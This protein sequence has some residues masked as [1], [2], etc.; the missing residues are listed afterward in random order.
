MGKKSIWLF[1]QFRA[2]HG[3]F[4]ARQSITVRAGEMMVYVCVIP[5]VCLFFS[6]R[7][8]CFEN[9][10]PD[11]SIDYII[12][13][14]FI[15]DNRSILRELV[16]ERTID[17]I[18]RKKIS[19]AFFRS[20]GFNQIFTASIKVFWFKNNFPLF[21]YQVWMRNIRIFFRFGGIERITTRAS[22]GDC[23]KELNIHF[24]NQLKYFHSSSF[25]LSPFV[26]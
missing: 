8:F 17:R 16:N 18:K 6:F 24:T 5:S 23:Q 10:L 25:F 20:I 26:Y 11:I 21:I 15:A 13:N 1:S 12:N 22:C 7:S 3:N 2:S 19:R 14:L 4:N 9:L